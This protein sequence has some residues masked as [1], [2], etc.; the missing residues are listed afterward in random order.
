MFQNR[1]Y[2]VYSRHRDLEAFQVTVKETDLHIQADTDLTKKAL[3]AVLQCRGYLESVIDRWPWF[4]TSLVPLTI[5]EP[6]PV[7]IREM[8]DAARLADVGP[9]AAVAGAVAE[10][11][12][13]ALLK[14]SKEVIVENGGDIFLKT[15]SETVFRI[16]AGKSPLSMKTGI[17]VPQ[18][19][20]PYG[21]CTSSGTLGHSKS[22]GKADAVT[23][24]ATSCPLA[25]ATATAL[26]NRIKSAGDI[27]QTIHTGKAIQGIQGIVIIKG[28]QLGI[29]GDLE[30][31]KLP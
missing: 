9:M 3:S 28:K 15:N 17:R 13:K 19:D 4:K 26:G 6:V 10:F 16:F 11:T 20:L 21:L 7:I 31:V 18:K 1:T 29:W 27:Q 12:G 24:I 30:L 22:F 23:V 25:D 14:D 2:R 8:L 5:E